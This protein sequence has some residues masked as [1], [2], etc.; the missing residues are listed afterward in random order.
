M[1]PPPRPLRR[2][3]GGEPPVTALVLLVGGALALAGV[4][5]VTAARPHGPVPDLDGLYDRWGELHG[6]LDPRASRWVRGWLAL[7]YR[8][9]APLARRGVRPDALTLW[10]IWLALVVV[11]AALAGGGWLVG[12]A[13]VLVLSA[14][15]DALDGAVAAL[16]D[17][18]T[19]WGAL[20]DAL[21]DRLNDVAYLL[22]VWLAGA[23]GWL[24]VGAGVAVGLLEYVRARAQAVGAVDLPVTLG[25]RP[26]R[27]ICCTGALL[28]AGLWPPLG[29][30]LA[31]LWLA[32]LALLTAVALWQ[33]VAAARRA[34]R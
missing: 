3:A 28:S 11:A 32:A 21:A 34:L 22:A 19:R 7:T 20:F 2:A 18:A 16:T 13:A 17:R 10:S 8:L 4:A 9:A 29:G 30:P 27:V 6:G 31:T 26:T 12:G 15:A 33:L 25:E 1:R 5:A 23:P 14:A 24:A